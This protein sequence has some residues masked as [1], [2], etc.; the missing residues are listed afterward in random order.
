MNLAASPLVNR[1]VLQEIVQS[2]RFLLAETGWDKKLIRKKRQ[3]GIL[4]QDTFLEGKNYL[5]SVHQEF[6]D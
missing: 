2:G 3:G 5:T 1:E 6:S 4:G